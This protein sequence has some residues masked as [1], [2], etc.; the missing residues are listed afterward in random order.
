MAT[1]CRFMMRRIKINEN[2]KEKKKKE[3]EYYET[4]KPELRTQEKKIE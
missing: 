4:C 1:L 3:E 2:D